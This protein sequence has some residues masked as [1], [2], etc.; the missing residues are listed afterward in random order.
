MRALL[1]RHRVHARAVGQRLVRVTNARNP[2][3]APPRHR[4]DASPSDR[5]GSS[6]TNS[7]GAPTRPAAPRPRT[8]SAPL[9][10]RSSPSAFCRYD[11]PGSRYPS[12][13]PARR[14]RHHRDGGPQPIVCAHKSVRQPRRHCIDNQ[15]QQNDS[16]AKEQI[17]ERPAHCLPALPLILHAV[18]LQ[19]PLLEQ[20][21]KP[22]RRRSCSN[23][24]REIRPEKITVSIGNFSSRKCVLKK[25]IVKIIRAQQRLVRMHDQRD[26]DAPPRQNRVKNCGNHITSPDSPITATPQ[27]TPK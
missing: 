11:I 14:R 7:S 6:R 18:L 5:G 3:A 15:D 23:S 24:V 26:V 19:L 16:D 17:A 10:P 4:P 20:P 25:W 12:G 2:P 1:D 9:P 21:V 8:T 13:R 22:P 27:K